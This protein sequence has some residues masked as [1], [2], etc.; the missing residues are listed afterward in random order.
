[1]ISILFFYFQELSP[2]LPSQGERCNSPDDWLPHAVPSSS[3]NPQ[4]SHQPL[5]NNQNKPQAFSPT[6]TPVK[7]KFG[8][9]LVKE[10]NVPTHSLRGSSAPHQ[11]SSSSPREV[12]LNNRLSRERQTDAVRYTNNLSGQ[13]RP[14]ASCDPHL[15]ANV[16]CNVIG[17]QNNLEPCGQA[18]S[19]GNTES[20]PLNNCAQ[21]SAFIRTRSLDRDSSP[22]SQP[23]IIN[24]SIYPNRPHTPIISLQDSPVTSPRLNRRL[25]N[26]GN[27]ELA[28]FDL[29]FQ[30]RSLTRTVDELKQ[31]LTSLDGQGTSSDEERKGK[32]WV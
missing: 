29:E 13:S 5:P 26:L 28:D 4:P 6:A 32:K 17:Q 16:T 12:M 10:Q 11:A 9:H 22:T 23:R 3:A 2:L 30:I 27:A 25:L 24:G 21:K 8:S 31:S 20:K 1:M 14:Q 15:S 19:N 18:I 7:S